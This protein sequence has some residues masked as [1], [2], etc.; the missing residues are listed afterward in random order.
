MMTELFTYLLGHDLALFDS[1]QLMTKDR[2]LTTRSICACIPANL[3]FKP[4]LVD[5]VE[6]TGR[7][8]HWVTNAST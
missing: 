4:A 3:T 5:W 6:D 1:C 7:L 2:N 8:T